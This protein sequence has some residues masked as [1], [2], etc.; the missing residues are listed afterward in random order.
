MTQHLKTKDQ[1]INRLITV[2]KIYGEE[3]RSVRL[4]IDELIDYEIEH[5]PALARELAAYKR[6]NGRARRKITRW[7][8]RQARRLRQKEK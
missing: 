6:R 3:S 5:A 7:A 8:R 4:A 2:E 1:L